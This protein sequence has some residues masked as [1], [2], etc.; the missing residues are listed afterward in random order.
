MERGIKCHPV[1]FWAFITALILVPFIFLLLT[2]PL[3]FVFSTGFFAMGFFSL[4]LIGPFYLL[5]GGPIYWHTVRR[6]GPNYRHT[7]IATIFAFFCVLIITSA[8]YSLHL[9]DW[10]AFFTSLWFAIL[11]SIVMSIWGCLFLFYT[12]NFKG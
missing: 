2:I 7:M 10:D 11:G 1:S 6:F 5:L 4:Y 8:A 9:L 3:S 12:R